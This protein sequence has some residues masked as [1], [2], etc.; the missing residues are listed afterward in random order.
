MSCFFRCKV[1]R[2]KGRRVTRIT[3]NQE[4]EI[5][6]SGYFHMSRANKLCKLRG[7]LFSR[8]YRVSDES[9]YTFFRCSDWPKMR[10]NYGWHRFD[11]IKKELLGD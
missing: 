10:V 1:L 4:S 9:R 11:K 6:Y 2:N 5:G 8:F 7:P 3:F